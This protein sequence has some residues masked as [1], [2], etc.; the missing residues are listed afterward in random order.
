MVSSDATG[1]SAARTAAQF[2]TTH[3]SVVFAA[4]HG[5]ST[6]AAEALNELCRTYWYPL[7]AY[8]RRTGSS[9]EDAEDLTQGFFRHLVECRLVDSADAAKGRFRSFLLRSFCNF[10][11]TEHAHATRQKRGGGQTILSLDAA[12][13]EAKFGR[14][15][16]DTNNPE[17]LY[18]RNWALAVLDEAMLQVEREFAA[19]GREHV[20]QVLRPY[21]QGDENALSHAAAGRELSTTEATVGVMVYRLRR[22]YREVLNGVVLRTVSSPA[23]VEEE[24]RY[25]LQV[26]QA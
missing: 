1:N 14:D 11:A 2:T 10:K 15:L 4:G 21:L 22:R 16:S 13:A 3:W 6:S 8:A 23:E 5:G 25:L 26:V 20:F 17:A 7:Y 19:S 18:A 9:P 24:L 12:G